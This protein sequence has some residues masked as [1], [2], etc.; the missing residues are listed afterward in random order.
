MLAPFPGGKSLRYESIDIASG[1]GGIRCLNQPMVA[2]PREISRYMIGIN[3]S[4]ITGLQELPK[5]FFFFCRDVEI[6][7]KGTL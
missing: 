7:A 6:V 4:D 5:D 3:C 1:G 2:R